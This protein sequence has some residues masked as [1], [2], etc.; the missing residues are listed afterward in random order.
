MDLRILGP[1]LV[2]GVLAILCAYPLSHVALPAWL[3]GQPVGSWGVVGVGGALLALLSVGLAGGMAAIL[4]PERPRSAGA[5]AGFVAT[6]PSVAVCGMP[7][8]GL[9][10]AA[11]LITAPDTDPA[12]MA[13]RLAATMAGVVGLPAL[14]ALLGPAL[15]ASLGAL[16]ASIV[17]AHDPEPGPSLEPVALLPLALLPILAILGL[18]MTLALDQLAVRVGDAAGPTAAL[19]L[20]LPLVAQ[21]CATAVTVAVAVRHA[22]LAWDDDARLIIGLRILVV[23]GVLL[24]WCGAALLL[25]GVGLGAAVPL[26]AGVV[27]VFLGLLWAS[28]EPAQVTARPRRILDALAR[29]PLAGVLLAYIVV[30]SVSPGLV[31]SL[32]VVDAMPW[33]AGDAARPDFAVSITKVLALHRVLLPVVFTAGVLAYLV[34]GV[35]VWALRRWRVGPELGT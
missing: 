8:I 1:A 2:L 17:A 9:L 3:L 10:G 11:S 14:L 34:A 16:L 26:V 21:L 23:T 19:T 6:L 12:L 27:G 31:A 22:A 5:S 4:T 35:P 28:R 25:Q 24:A 33:L 30:L 20:L 15:G 7:A 32:V 13:T 29:A 18:A